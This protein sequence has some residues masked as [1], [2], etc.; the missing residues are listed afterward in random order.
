MLLVSVNSPYHLQKILLK[1]IYLSGCGPTSLNALMR[2]VVAAKIDP[3]RIMKGDMRG[4]IDF[5][6]EDFDY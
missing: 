1:H 4:Y 5:M 2:K 6:C 3:K